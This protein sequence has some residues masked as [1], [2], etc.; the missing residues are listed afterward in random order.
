MEGGGQGAFGAGSDIGFD[1]TDFAHAGDDGGDVFVVEDEAEG[2]FG[3]GHAVLEK[4]LERFGV[5]HAGLEIFRDEIGVA[6]VAFW[7]G[8]FERKSSGERAFVERDAG[9]DGDIFFS[10]RG[11]KFVFGILVEDVVDDLDC[12]DE[13]GAHGANAVTRLPAIETDADGA[14]FAAAAEIFDGARKA[15]VVEPFV[16]PS[17]KLNEVDDIGADVGETFFDV[18]DDV[19]GREAIV[20]RKFAAAGPAAIFRRNFGGDVK[21]FVGAGVGGIL[22][23]AQNFPE[24]L[25][26]VAVAIGPGSVE[27]VAAE[28]DGT[29]ERCERFFILRAGLTGESPHTITNF[30]NVPSGA[31]E[32][33]V[34]HGVLS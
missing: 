17:V 31:A 24:K 34:V 9:D 14:Y 30:A 12:I 23:G 19:I 32:A 6:P 16:F 33:A 2:H 1:V 27:E 20:E 10:A 15:R 28:I 3:H 25:F 5:G 7:P 4:R 29:L 22:I 21:L 8:A 11:E 26:A 18:L 13:A